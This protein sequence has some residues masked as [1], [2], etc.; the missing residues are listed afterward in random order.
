MPPLATTA[1]IV[2]KAIHGEQTVF[3]VLEDGSEVELVAYSAEVVMRLHEFPRVRIEME[4][5]SLSIE[6]A[7]EKQPEQGGA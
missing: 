6:P 7:G 5:H 1:K 4:V 2:G 3:A